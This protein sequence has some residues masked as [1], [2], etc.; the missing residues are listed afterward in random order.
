MRETGINSGFM[1]PQYTAALCIGKQDPVPSGVGRFDS[2][3]P[4]PGRSRQHGQHRGSQAVDGIS[5]CRACA[6]DRTAHA[7]QAARLPCPAATGPGRRGSPHHHAT[8]IPHRETTTSSRTSWLACWTDRG[9]ALLDAVAAAGSRRMI[10]NELAIE[11]L[12]PSG[13]SQGRGHRT[14]R[15][16][17]WLWCARPRN[18]PRP[19]AGTSALQE[20]RSKK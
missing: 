17:S 15:P 6:G 7:A 9:T 4:G 5:K 2:D 10:C 14:G 18:L 11:I 20:H 19:Q 8:I 12:F 16:T 3:Q 13:A 1:I